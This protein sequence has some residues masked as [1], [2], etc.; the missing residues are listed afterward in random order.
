MNQLGFLPLIL[1]YEWPTSIIKKIW[2][3]HLWTKFSRFET[4]QNIPHEHV[5]VR[6]VKRLHACSLSKDIGWHNRPRCDRQDVRKRKR[7]K[8][9][10]CMLESSRKCRLDLERPPF[11][12]Y[13]RSGGAKK[14]GMSNVIFSPTPP[15]PLPSPTCYFVLPPLASQNYFTYYELKRKDYGQLIGR[16]LIPKVHVFFLHAY[17]FRILMDAICIQFILWI[18]VAPDIH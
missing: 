15:P 18:N 8:E 16:S 14:Y 6:S 5:D 17:F 10:A 3:S 7:T 9:G 12:A 4:P 13:W 2:V 11:I 1:L